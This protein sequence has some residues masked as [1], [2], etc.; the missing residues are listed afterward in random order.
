M[1]KLECSFEN[2]L[3][4]ASS[5]TLAGGMANGC[6]TARSGGPHTGR[7]CEHGG[8]VRQDRTRAHTDEAASHAVESAFLG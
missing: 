6:P 5:P 7:G 2:A 3:K 1:Q 8:A 4:L